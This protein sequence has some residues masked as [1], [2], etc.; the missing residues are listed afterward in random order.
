MEG[1]SCA[2]VGGAVRQLHAPAF[3]ENNAAADAEL[4]GIHS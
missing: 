3:V 4:E 1:G 2:S